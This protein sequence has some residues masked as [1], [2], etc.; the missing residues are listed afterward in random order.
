MQKRLIVQVSCLFLF[1]VTVAAQQP[2][3]PD[4]EAAAIKQTLTSCSHAFESRDARA[5]A[6]CFTEDADFTGPASASVHGR[7]EIEQL[8]EKSFA[9]RQDVHREYTVKKIRFLSPQI[10]TVENQWKV[11][12]SQSGGSPVTPYAGVHTL[13][14]IKEKGNWQIAIFHGSRFRPRE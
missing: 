2:S 14:V 10:A 12:G 9:R 1:S 3:N 4:A 13:V 7:K 5:A 8:F 6:M 11:T